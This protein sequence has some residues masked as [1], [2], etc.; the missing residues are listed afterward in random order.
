MKLSSEHHPVTNPMHYLGRDHPYETVKV[1]EAWMTPEEFVGFLKGN[2]LK[3]LSR[4]RRKGGDQD[5]E[6]AK[7]YQDYLVEFQQRQ[8]DVKAKAGGW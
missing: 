5:L 1:L 4:H 6:K 3:Y 8:A 7:F 2:T